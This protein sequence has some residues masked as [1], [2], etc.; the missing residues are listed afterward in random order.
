MKMLGK[1]LKKNKNIIL[2]ALPSSIKTEGA[3]LFEKD[4]TYYAVTENVPMAADTHV[5]RILGDKVVHLETEKKI[6]GGYMVDKPSEKIVLKDPR[7]FNVYPFGYG[8]SMGARVA[9]FK[10]K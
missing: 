8:T 1:W 10:L 2:D 7:T 3:Y 9:A 5:Q 4:G 6:V